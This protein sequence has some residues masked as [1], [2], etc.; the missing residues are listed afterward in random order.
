MNTNKAV[1]KEKIVKGTSI[2]MPTSMV[3]DLDEIAAQENRSRSNLIV[4]MLREKVAEYR[5]GK[6]AEGSK[7]D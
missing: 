7:H 4:L 1:G 5:A 3:R 6:G 2:A